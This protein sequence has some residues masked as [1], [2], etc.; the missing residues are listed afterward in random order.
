MAT[1]LLAAPNKTSTTNIFREALLLL[2]TKNGE[3]MSEEETETVSTAIIPLM[4]LPEYFN[5]P[6]PDGLEDLARMVE[7]TK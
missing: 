7:E 3:D 2:S 1:Q 4:L 6:I 5:I